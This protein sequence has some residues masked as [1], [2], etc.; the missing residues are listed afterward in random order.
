MYVYLMHKSQFILQH[1]WRFTYVT[2]H[3]TALP[4]L[5]LRHRH[6]TYVKLFLKP[7]RLILQPLNRFT[8]VT[9][10]S[11]ALPLLHLRH[12][13]N[14]TKLGS[15]HILYA[16]RPR[17]RLACYPTTGVFNLL[18]SRANLHLSYSLILR[19]AVI[20]DYRIIMDIVNIIG[21]WAA[22]QVT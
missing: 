17:R 6:F 7:F 16:D 10:H 1:F 4:L 12:R 15:P 3:C 13:Q 18:S 14:K 2:A 8:Y 19:A 20:A 11:I 22:R 21:V 9:A 5:H